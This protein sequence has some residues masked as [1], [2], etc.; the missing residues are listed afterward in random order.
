MKKLS[1]SEQIGQMVQIQ[2][3]HL[4]GDCSGYNAGP[5]NPS[6]AHQVLSHGSRRLDPVRRR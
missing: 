1:L 4:Y 6:C 3:G 2:V 5:L